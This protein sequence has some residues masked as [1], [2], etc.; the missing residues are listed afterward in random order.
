MADKINSK[1]KGST[2]ERNVSKL[3]Q[4]WTGFEFA[5]VPSSGGLRWK[6]TDKTVGDLI[7]TDDKHSRYF[8]F[9]IEAKFY[10]EIN[11]EHLLLGNKKVKILE[12]WQQ[13]LDDS[14][15]AKKIPLVTMRYNG[16]KKDTH[17]VILDYNYYNNISHL[18]LTKHGEM[19]F[20]NGLHKIIII[21]SLDL[22]ESNYEKIHKIN[23]KYLKANV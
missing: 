18:L 2:N 7:C 17:F 9:T 19:T 23:K 6:D 12:F 16:M 5:R 8:R 14:I 15:R 4:A 22:F 1:N 21:N 3:F 20:S 11:F 13:S 10:K